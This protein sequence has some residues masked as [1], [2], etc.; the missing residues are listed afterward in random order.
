[1]RLNAE[2]AAPNP[3][4]SRKYSIFTNWQGNPHGKAWGKQ[5]QPLHPPL[6]QHRTVRALLARKKTARNA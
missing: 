1:M 6:Q 5:Q 2:S 3:G 4:S